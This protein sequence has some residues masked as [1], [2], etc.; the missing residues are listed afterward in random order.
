MM[1]QVDL[2]SYFPFTS[3]T[4]DKSGTWA[5]KLIQ[6]RRIR[7]ETRRNIFKLPVCLRVRFA[8]EANT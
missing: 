2:Q 8:G 7:A 5:R 1:T 3:L 4:R 6:V